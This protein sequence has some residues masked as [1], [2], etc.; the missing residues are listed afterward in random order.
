MNSICRV[1]SVLP[2]LHH[3][4]KRS[5]W[6]KREEEKSALSKRFT[7]LVEH[8]N[9][10]SKK[11]VLLRDPPKRSSFD[12]AARTLTLPSNTPPFHMLTEAPVIGWTINWS[13]LLKACHL[14][15]N[16]PRHINQTGGNR[17]LCWP[18]AGGE[19]R[20]SVTL[21]KSPQEAMI[22]KACW[23]KSKKG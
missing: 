10:P 20:S 7:G 3:G 15:H 14:A 8:S 4:K 5:P 18:P 23:R 1:A 6:K 9:I 21:S 12:S 2:C 22:K 17:G 11:W 19:G 16:Q 13:H